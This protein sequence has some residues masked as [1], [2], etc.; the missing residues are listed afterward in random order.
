VFWIVAASL[1]RGDFM[2]RVGVFVVVASLVS[3][4]FGT[5]VAGAAATNLVK[6]SGFESPVVGDGG[7]QAFAKGEAF[8]RWSVVGAPGDVGVVSGTFAQDGFTFPSNS[9]QQWL[10]LTGETSNAA[11][12]VVQSVATTVGTPY[13]LSFAVG[14]LVDPGGVWGTS[15]TVKV[16]V[17]GVLK[18]VA[19]NSDGAGSTAQ[20]WKQFSV[21]FTAAA[22][23]TGIK[24]VNG[25]H[26]ADNLNGLDS[27]SV[28]PS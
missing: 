21:N 10:D 9:G 11:T 25:D 12:G 14:N 8:F 19:T 6:D 5:T 24:F 20:V 23:A 3:A 18:L 26:A 1:L 4:L 28:V 13:T 7:S 2:R 15:S 22:A 27:V 16:Y 17:G